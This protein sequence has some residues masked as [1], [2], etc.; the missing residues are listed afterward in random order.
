MAGLG[1][2]DN[3][4]HFLAFLDEWND[5]LPSVPIDHVIADCEKTA[6]ISVDLICGFCEEGPL[7]SPRVAAIVE[8]AVD[9]MQ[10]LWDHK[11]RHFVLNQDNHPP[12][13]VEFSEFG[14]HCV[15]GTREAETVE[16]IKQLPFFDWMTVILKNSIHSSM[17]TEFN[18]WLEKN[19]QVDTFVVAGDCTDLCVYQLAMDLKLQANARQ[20]QR[21][22]ILPVNCI[23]T[24]DLPVDVAKR[25]G[26]LPHPGELMHQIFIYHMALNGVE[27]VKEILP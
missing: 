23:D 19:S 7:A 4:Q 3:T 17:N 9:L 27:V 1:E 25:L 26:I 15:A 14:P 18:Q 22:V 11:V 12:D 2:H 10:L 6:F 20:Q 24:Y 16:A 21:R 5:S 8:P 13:A